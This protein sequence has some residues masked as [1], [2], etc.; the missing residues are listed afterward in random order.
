MTAMQL[1]SP[2]FPKAHRR[3]ASWPLNPDDLKEIAELRRQRLLCGW[4]SD[5]IDKWLDMIRKGDRLMFWI[6]DDNDNSAPVEN[7]PRFCEYL[8]GVDMHQEEIPSSDPDFL[9]VGHFALDWIDY[10]GDK[11]LADRDKGKITFTSLY[12]LMSKRGKGY[13]SKA[14]FEAER[15]AK[16]ELH[17]SIITLNTLPARYSTNADWWASQGLK[18]PQVPV[19]EEWYRSNGYLAYL[20]VL[21]HKYRTIDGKECTVPCVNM[22][23]RL[24]PDDVD[25]AAGL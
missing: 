11:T 10:L 19:Y 16:D 1:S 18:Q 6:V 14:L 24:K 4:G 9:P 20:E 5:S 15:I 7:E 8:D 25:Y 23:K 13:A 22:E 17:C 21:R 12:V 2:G 3:P